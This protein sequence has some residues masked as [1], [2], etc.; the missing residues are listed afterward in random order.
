MID[1]IF[2]DNRMIDIKVG[3]VTFYVTF[4]YGDHVRQH[5]RA[6]WDKLTDIRVSRDEAWFLVGDYNDIINNLE[7][8]GGPT[9]SEAT[10]F[11][12]RSLARD[13]RIKEVPSFGN[14][15]S[16]VGMREMIQTN[17]EKENVWIQCRLDRAFRNAE[18]FRLFPK[19]HIEYLQRQGSDQARPMVCASNVFVQGPAHRLHNSS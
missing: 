8:I 14:K 10:F 3:S 17:G 18:C 19:V 11:S 1:I 4:V 2:S 9:R 16:W 6:I 5:R 13:C 12:F 7:K 15:F